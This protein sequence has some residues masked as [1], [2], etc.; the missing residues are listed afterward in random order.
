MVN[1]TWFVSENTVGGSNLTVGLTWAD[2]LEINGFNRTSCA[3]A[4]F[5]GVWSRGTLGAA[6]GPNPFSRT[7]AGVTAFSAFAIGDVNATLLP[8]Q[9]IGFAG[10][11]VD[12]GVKLNWSTV[13]ERNNSRFEVQRANDGVT[14]ETIGNVKGNGNTNKLI[15]YTFLDNN[16]FNASNMVYYRLKQVDF[17]GKFTFSEAIGFSNNILDVNQI[18]AYPNPFASDVNIQVNTADE[19]NMNLEISDATG[20]VVTN[21]TKYVKSG[22]QLIVLTELKVLDDGVYFVNATIN[23]LTQRIKLVKYND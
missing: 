15:R 6:T 12:D 17:D 4:V 7:I 1:R 23:G 20:K 10:V 9:L 13:S 5:N 16:P 21:L 3:V 18:S 19:G 22:T 14:F 8:V 11:K 2:T